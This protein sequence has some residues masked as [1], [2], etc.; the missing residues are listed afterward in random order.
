MQGRDAIEYLALCLGMLA[1][2]WPE[3]NKHWEGG[4]NSLFSLIGSG[5]DAGLQEAAG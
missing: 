1:I 4:V 5:E 2:N 3:Q